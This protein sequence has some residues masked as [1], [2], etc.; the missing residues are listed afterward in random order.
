M[1]PIE[2]DPVDRAG[3]AFPQPEGVQDAPIVPALLQ[4]P[5]L[6]VISQQAA[7]AAGTQ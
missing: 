1:G 2:E 5:L 6:F 7:T 3:G 4:Y